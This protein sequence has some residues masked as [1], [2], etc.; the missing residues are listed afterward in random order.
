VIYAFG[1]FIYNP[2]HMTIP[3][4]LMAHETV[5]G[6]RQGDNPLGWWEQYLGDMNFRIVEE[7]LAHRARVHLSSRARQPTPTALGSAPHGQA[8]S[9]AAVR[10]DDDQ[11]ASRRAAQAGR[12]N[13][14]R[15]RGNW[16]I[17]AD[18]FLTTAFSELNAGEVVCI[19]EAKPKRENPSEVWFNSFLETDRAFRKWNPDKQ[20]RAMYTIVSTVTGAL[21]DKGTM[22][23]RKRSDLVRVHLL[24]LDD[25]GD[26]TGAPPVAPSYKLETSPASFHWGYFLVPDERIQLFEALVEA[27]HQQGWGDKGAGGSYRAVRLPGSANLKPGRQ[28]FRSRIVEWTPERYWTLEE[29]AGAFGLDLAALPAADPAPVS[30]KAGGALAMDGID[31][32]LDWLVDGGHVV[33]DGGGDWVDIV[34]PW[35]DAHTSGANTA[36][37]S[38]WGVAA[39]IGCRPAPSAACMSTAPIASWA[40]SAPGPSSSAARL[41]AVTIRC[42]G[43]RSGSPTSPRVRWWPTC[44]SGPRAASGCGT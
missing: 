13:V 26:K 7:L 1:G 4:E 28:K 37:Y 25:I 34:C 33:A 18:E 8:I 44:T 2:T 35:A 31:P 3:P 12:R 40:P 20:A 10:R 27:I 21:N 5:H 16:M 42:R 43:Y 15:E 38:P 17:T 23:S 36:G 9:R 39:G 29:L 30:S 19:T 32:M 14:E 6:Q 41:S 24:V 22:V 11:E